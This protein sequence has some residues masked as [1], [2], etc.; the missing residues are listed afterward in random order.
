MPAVTA[1][2]A[3]SDVYSTTAAHIRP[4]VSLEIVQSIPLISHMYRNGVVR[5]SGG[6][7][8]RQP[9]VINENDPNVGNLAK[10]ETFTTA[11]T[12]GPD[13]ARYDRDSYTGTV[14]S[15]FMIALEDMADNSKAEQIV[16]LTSAKMAQAKQSML[17]KLSTDM[18]TAQ[19]GSAMRGLPDFLDFTS[20]A[21]QAT[22]SVLTPG[23]I[24][25]QTY[26]R[27]RNRFRQISFSAK[28]A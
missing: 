4:E 2:I 26:A 1:S 20:E 25:K 11:P 16:S 19:A 3:L 15:S 28:L 21:V 10:Y 23:G 24:S 7:D 9:V 6:N 13:T 8:I 12:D 17:N 18:Y 22:S 27:W 14:R 5:Y